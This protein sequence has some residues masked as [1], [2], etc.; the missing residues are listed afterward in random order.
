MALQDYSEDP[1]LNG[2]VL[3]IDIGEDCPAANINGGMRQIMADLAAWVKG[4]IFTGLTKIRDV[5]GDTGNAILR[6]TNN[7]GSSTLGF[8]RG[9]PGGGLTLGQNA[10]EVIRIT[11]F[12][13]V[14]IG[15]TSPD[16][17]FH[18]AG[19]IGMSALRF[20][21]NANAYVY[22]DANRSSFQGDTNDSYSFDR[23]NNLHEFYIGGVRQG[24]FD[25]AGRVVATTEI[26]AT[27]LVRIGGFTNFFLNYN[28]G[29]PYVNFGNNCYIQHDDTNKHF[30]F[31]QNGSNVMAS[32]VNGMIMAG[33]NGGFR[34]SG[35][36]NAAGLYVNGAGVD[37]L[38][39]Q[40]S[41]SIGYRKY[42][43]GYTEAWGFL[44]VPANTFNYRVNYPAGTNFASW[45]NPQL[46][47]GGGSQQDND[48]Y[49]TNPDTGGFY[50]T[51]RL[52]GPANVWWQAKGF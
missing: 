3:G 12:S 47:G 14:G 40:N 38:V 8:V 4:A 10:S 19:D 22:S 52:S 24:Y 41:A 26:V 32:G 31:V 25:G 42:A 45:S 44:T 39:A 36:L 1:D 15:T 13:R 6:F 21:G 28:G 11:P 48:P 27:T 35:T 18:V 7:A 30:N 16:W 23:I 20:N 34:G 29:N 2:L 49:A 17:P 43:S 33:A 46:T 51:N 50:I 9:L 5:A 37:A